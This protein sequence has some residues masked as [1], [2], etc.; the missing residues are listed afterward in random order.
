M[1]A[2][3]TLPLAP[4]IPSYFSTTL[5]TVSPTTVGASVFA[6]SVVLVLLYSAIAI[7]H[8]TRYGHRSPVA[9]PAICT[10]IFASLALI[11]FAATGL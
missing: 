8:W 10:H 2:S 11:G 9:I 5:G 1:H 4:H 3:T 7:Y 6:F